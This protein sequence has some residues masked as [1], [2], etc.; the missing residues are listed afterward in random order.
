MINHRAIA[1]AA[2]G[3][4]TRTVDSPR[5]AMRLSQ[6][7]VMRLLKPYS[8][9]S[10]SCLPRCY[11]CYRG[12]TSSRGVHA[13]KGDLYGAEF[14][15]VGPPSDIR[16][17]IV[18]PRTPTCTTISMYDFLGRTVEYWMA[19]PRGWATSTAALS[20]PP[21][22]QRAL[23]IC[24]TRKTDVARMQATKTLRRHFGSVKGSTEPLSPTALARM[25]ALLL[26][27]EWRVGDVECVAELFQVLE[28][29][30]C[31]TL[32]SW[33][34]GE[35]PPGTI[36][37]GMV[38]APTNRVVSSMC[39]ELA[40]AFVGWA[41]QVDAK[42]AVIADRAYES[43]LGRA[44]SKLKRSM[45]QVGSAPKCVTNCL[46]PPTGFSHAKDPV[47][48]RVA[49]IIREMCDSAG[50]TPNSIIDL[51]LFQS[52]WKAHG[53][54]AHSGYIS[55]NNGIHKVGGKKYS[56]SCGAMHAAGGCPHG[57]DTQSCCAQA[58]KQTTVVNTPIA[59]WSSDSVSKR[60]KPM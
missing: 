59:V 6:P 41:W 30:H 13:G 17:I 53:S 9:L 46:H 45:M 60:V 16:V 27:I 37:D 7:D 2:A 47:R 3:R 32:L 25:C 10:F 22:C 56:V 43:E 19:Y 38:H 1:L 50:V 58:G 15:F 21:Y 54:G 20:I 52:Q 11:A 8:A 4:G 28:S 39:E 18:D 24:M 29:T 48:W 44:K 33:R 23:L 40:A 49:S 55:L 14:V 12:T 5:G 36:V 26:G 35:Q 51:D 42:D 31:R 57:G 34:G